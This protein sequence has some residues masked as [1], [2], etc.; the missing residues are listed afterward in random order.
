MIVKLDGKL[1]VAGLTANWPAMAWDDF[2]P[3]AEPTLIAVRRG[4]G[5]RRQRKQAERG[6]PG[7]S[8]CANLSV[9]AVVRA[10]QE[11]ARAF[12]GRGAFFFR[13]VKGWR[14]S[15]GRASDL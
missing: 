12:S 13:W 1:A 4:A 6:L 8:G 15:A 7:R 3:L 9:Y 5:E 11:C 10:E 2:M 14:S